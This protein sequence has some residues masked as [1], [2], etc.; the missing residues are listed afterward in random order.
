[1]NI[2]KQ[3]KILGHTFKVILADTEDI[4]NDAGEMNLSRNTIKIRKDLPQDQI[5]ESLL[6]EIIHAINNEL[7]EIDVE[8]LAQTIYAVLK[9]NKL[10]K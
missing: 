8:F 2:P 6:H 7:K 4:D 5:E 9:E 10:L 1:M 3:L